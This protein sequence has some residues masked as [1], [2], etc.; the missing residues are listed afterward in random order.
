MEMRYVQRG[1]CRR[2]GQCC[3]GENCE[4]LQINDNGLATCRIF[5]CSDRPLKCGLFPE[6]PPIPK[7][8]KNCGYYFLDTWEENKVVTRK[9]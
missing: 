4:H 7:S 8:F 5:N 3:L 6:M 1:K 2:C 9:L